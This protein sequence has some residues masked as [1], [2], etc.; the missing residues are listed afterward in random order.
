MDEHA[1]ACT[2]EIEKRSTSARRYLKTFSSTPVPSLE[3][4]FTLNHNADGRLTF[5]DPGDVPEGVV[6]RVVDTGGAGA[7]LKRHIV[8]Q[9]VASPTSSPLAPQ[10]MTQ[11]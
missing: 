8:C 5:A 2:P 6:R 9:P 7:R 3:A 4:R 11:R 1:L 10:I